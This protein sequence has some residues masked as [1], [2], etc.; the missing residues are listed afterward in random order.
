MSLV[1]AVGIFVAVRVRGKWEHSAPIMAPRLTYG[2]MRRVSE[3]V[4]PGRRFR[5]LWLG[6][7]LLTWQ[8]A[9]G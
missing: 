6:R 3:Q 2:Q 1:G 8:P 4:L 9:P 5:R 7:Y